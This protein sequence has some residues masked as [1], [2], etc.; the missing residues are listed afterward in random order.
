MSALQLINLGFNRLSGPMPDS[1]GTLNNLDTLFLNQNRLTGSI[2]L[3]FS[4][5]DLDFFFVSANNLDF[6]SNSAQQPALIPAALQSWFAAIPNSNVN[7]QSLSDEIFYSGF[8]ENTG[9]I[10]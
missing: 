5:L 7:L 1:L 3:S 4:N 8:D 2:P 6:D 9:C 10:L